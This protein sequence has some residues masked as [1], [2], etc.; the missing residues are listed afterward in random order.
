MK[1]S[2]TKQL[3]GSIHMSINSHVLVLLIVIP[4][5]SGMFCATEQDLCQG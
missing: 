4:N 1:Q 3:V 5:V 2:A